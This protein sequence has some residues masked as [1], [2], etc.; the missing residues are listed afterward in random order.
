M[1]HTLTLN[2]AIDRIL[3][4]NEL[5][6]NVTNRVKKTTDTIGGKGTHVSINLKLLGQDNNAFGICHG[7]NGRQV[8]QM[9]SDYGIDVRFNHYM[10]D[11]KETR[12]N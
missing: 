7:E 3:Y 12:T 10:E 1:I 6:K 4:L 9:L 5:E 8:I 11:N 2:P